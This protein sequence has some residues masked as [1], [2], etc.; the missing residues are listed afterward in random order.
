MDIEHRDHPWD[1]DRRVR[2]TLLACAGLD[3]AL[4]AD[5]VTQIHARDPMLLHSLKTH[6]DFA[7]AASQYYNVALQQFAVA[8]QL[9]AALF[10][11]DPPSILDFACGYGRFLRFAVFGLPHDG[12]HAAE[13]KS[14]A[15]DFVTQTFHVPGI[16]STTDPAAFEPQE[17]FDFIWVVSLFSHLPDALFHAWLAKLA[18]LLTPRGVLAFSVRGAE[19]LP[20]D[21]TLPNGIEFQSASEDAGLDPTIYGTSYV[22]AEYV[23]ETIARVTHGRGATQR[24]PRALA[25]E[26]DLW[27][28]APGRHDLAAVARIAYGPWGWLDVKRRDGRRLRLEGWAASLDGDAAVMADI[29]ING[30]QRAV[31]PDIAR[32]DVAAALRRTTLAPAGWRLELECVDAVPRWM[33]VL[34]RDAGGQRALLFAGEV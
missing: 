6:G 2:P 27:L 33:E 5:F 10:A 9:T 24:L 8:R 4:N 29:S 16:A 3:R 15:L 21:R 11:D 17:R 19:L 34:A 31:A 25:N 22:S 28:V 12:I 18:S 30:E 13:V 20:A 32:P 14:E 26:Q 1:I 7:T 23:A